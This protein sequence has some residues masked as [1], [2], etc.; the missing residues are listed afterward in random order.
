MGMRS[1]GDTGCVEVAVGRRRSQ[2]EATSG[3]LTGPHVSQDTSRGGRRGEPEGSCSLGVLNPQVHARL[4]GA[5]ADQEEKAAAV[6]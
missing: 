2:A 1:S 4:S 3:A 6:A 5:R